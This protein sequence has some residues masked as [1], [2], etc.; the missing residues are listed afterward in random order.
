[1][2]SVP[3]RANFLGE[4]PLGIWKYGRDSRAKKIIQNIYVCI[5]KFIHYTN[6]NYLYVSF[7]LDNELDFPFMANIGRSCTC[8]LSCVWLFVTLWTVAARLLCS[9]NFSG[10][11]TGVGCHFLLQGI[12]PAQ[13][14][15]P[16]LL[17]L[18]HCRW[19]PYL[20]R[21]SGFLDTFGLASVIFVSQMPHETD[22]LIS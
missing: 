7:L 21:H 19:I 20:L 13:E 10:K 3:G 4:V 8:M 16:C 14:S 18:Q 17:Y 6:Y 12:F 22:F 11:N 5:Y 15:N 2:M 9:W 1:M